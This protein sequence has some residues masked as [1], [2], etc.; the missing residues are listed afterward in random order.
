VKIA[1]L[2]EL[3]SPSVGGQEIRF[4]ELSE[5]L[6]HRG[7]SVEVF[8]IQNAPESLPEEVAGNIVV[9]RNPQAYSYQLPPLKWL[10]RRPAV[11]LR[12]ALQCRRMDS[13]DFDLFIFSQW[14]LAHILLAPASTRRKAIID[15]CEFRDGILFSLA[16]K[17]LPLL[18]SG[19]IANSIALKEKLEACSGRRFDCVPSG[20]HT[21]RYRCEPAAQRSGILY[22]GRIEE[23]KNLTLL[24]SSYESLV[25]SGYTGRLRIAGTG[26]AVSNL[27]RLVEASKVAAQID[28]T[29]YVGDAH[30]IELLAHSEVLVMPSRREGF[31]RVVAEAMAS[32]LP[33]VTA[34]Y[35]ENGTKDV[36]RQYGI[37]RVTRSTPE[38]IAQGVRAVL[39]NWDVYSK[40]CLSTSQSLDWEVLVDKLLQI[41]A[42]SQSRP[43]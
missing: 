28:L 43:S 5:V 34:D 14:P 32:G 40:S 21:S 6:T 15:W 23:H 37:G 12:Y 42:A 9:H 2:T 38:E 36:V 30:K 10:R 25:A 18:V 27:Q 33:V 19:N 29:G 3:F 26:R 41:V 16:Q 1:I 31:P 8:C 7:H 35:P 39:T 13:H 4:G 22:L 11:V 17:Y 24:L 20:V